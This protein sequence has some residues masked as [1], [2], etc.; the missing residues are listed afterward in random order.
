MLWIVWDTVRADRL[1]LYGHPKPTSPFLEE[2]SKSARVWERCVSVSCWTVPAHASMFT[3]RLPSEHGASNR[4]PRLQE[5]LTTLPE[6][7]QSHG[8]Q[9]YLF[10]GNPH[11]GSDHNFQ[12]GFDVEE[13]PWDPQ[14]R[15]QAFQ[16]LQ[17]KIDPEDQSS[18]L[19][20]LFQQ[21]E[22]LAWA[23][24]ASGTL[25]N[26]GVLQWLDARDPTRPFFA[27]LNY[28]EAHRPLLPPRDYRRRFMS[29][30]QVT[31]S[32]AVDRSY[33]SMWS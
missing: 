1:S 30:E 31:R 21:R 25:A 16:L 18:E 17:S 13:H 9:T 22:N 33:D 12:Q 3:G 24:R 20:E 32:Y 26:Q 23:I 6:I 27:F 5:G 8:F 4:H 28:M 7:L 19:P 15:M 10:S 2:W 14:Y 11:I 29:E